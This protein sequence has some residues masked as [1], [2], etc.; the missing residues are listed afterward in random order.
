MA[1]TLL[2]A[3]LVLCIASTCFAAEDKKDDKT[4]KSSDSKTVKTPR[5]NPVVERVKFFQAAGRDNELDSKEFTADQGKKNSFV[6]KTD[7]WAAISKYD[8]NENKMID[9]FEAD[10]Y[11]R[12]A[13]IKTK[14]VTITTVG[15]EPVPSPRGGDGGRRRGRGGFGGGFQ[16]SADAIEKFDK[17]GDKKLNE[18]ER[19]A[20]FESRRAEF[21]K[22]MMARLDTD[23]DGTVTDKEREA[24][25]AAWRERAAAEQAKRHFGRFDANN[26]GKLD[27]DE[28]KAHDAHVA[29]HKER[30]AKAQAERATRRKA[31]MKL[32]DKNENGQIDEEERA[33]IREYYRKRGEE[34]RAEMVKQFD[35]DGDKKLNE[36]ERAEM[37]RSFRSRRG[38]RDRRGGGAGGG[39]GG[40]FMGGRR[41]RRGRRP[42]DGGDGGGGGGGD[43]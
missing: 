21:R 40:G 36:E 6:R 2:T 12:S 27:P 9:W 30:D 18:T 11:R 28:Q 8:K 24:A 43:T 7:T 17:D 4:P 14:T 42:G 41:G 26:D 5:Y 16:P 1:R 10:R 22:R 37:M 33:G 23:G 34:R 32:H 38:G 20:Y 13:N 25:R 19:R 31:F 3:V 15:G 29:E 35:K 39:P